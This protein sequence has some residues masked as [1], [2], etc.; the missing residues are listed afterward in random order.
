MTMT[1]V[2]PEP[3]EPISPLK[4][5]QHPDKSAFGITATPPEREGEGLEAEK[6]RIMRLVEQYAKYG[7]HEPQSEL[8]IDIRCGL[9]TLSRLLPRA[10]VAG[11]GQEAAVDEMT[12]L[13]I[14]FAVWYHRALGA[15]ET[16]YYN[17]CIEHRNEKWAS[18]RE[19]TRRLAAPAPAPA[20]TPEQDVERIMGLVGVLEDRVTA[21]ARGATPESRAIRADK[22]HAA[23]T[24]VRDAITAAIARPTELEDGARVSSAEREAM[25]A[26]FGSDLGQVSAT[27]YHFS[28]TQE[29]IAV[30]WDEQQI[31]MI[32]RLLGGGAADGE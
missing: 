15:V 30:V 8:P 22:A 25:L 9:D 3:T 31:E 10:P 6:D 1:T 4:S 19:Y 7:V 18:I 32:K 5:A 27:G 21:W 14:D 29:E 23:Q 2:T 24:A 17:D 12:N 11:T 16:D 20:P 28:A 13:A 26:K